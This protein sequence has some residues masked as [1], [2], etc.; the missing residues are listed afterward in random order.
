MELQNARGTRDFLP[1][2]KIVR[3]EIRNTLVSM[4]ERYGFSP[5]ETPLLERFEV[6]S[7]KYAGGEEILKESFKLKDQGS[8][9][10][11]LRYD[12]TVPLSRVI[13]MNP[14]LKMPI[15]FYQIGQVFRDGPVSTARY[16]QFTQCDVDI[17]GVKSM[18]AETDVLAL[19]KDVFSALNVEVIIRIN[20]RK[21]LND[22]LHYCDIKK[23]HHETVILSIDKLEKIG[24]S[25]VKKELKQKKISEKAIHR[26]EEILS[27]TGT[28]KEKLSEIKKAI[29]ETQGLQEIDELLQHLES[30]HVEIVFDHSLA[31]GLSYYTGTVFEV[32]SKDNIVA[33]AI[34]AGGR[35]D[36]MIGSLLGRG[37]Y[38]A[39]G[40]SFG[41]DRLF[42]VLINVK[43]PNKVVVTKLYIIP[44]QETT[45]ALKIL[46]FF[47]QN[48]IC[49]D[50][51][52]SGRG[53]SKNLD[54]AHAQKI[55]YVL[56]VGKKELEHGKVKLRDMISGNEELLPKEEVLKKLQ[57]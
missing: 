54:F 27:I 36:D 35:Y 28:N 33:S 38:P 57:E 19:A 37:E 5:L 47:R 52:F 51:D 7:S 9:D 24:L 11:G 12:L 17:I 6:L 16:R 43:T 2:E 23:E 10:L 49:A 8:R 45:E 56:F 31:R 15:K 55:P 21:V 25:E 48:G 34:S 32:N 1:K 13:G 42:D 26:I 29:G 20:N 22:L 44:I 14:Q 3:D 4:F 39:V 41:L 40:I 53:P 46:S 18:L 50:M 30:I